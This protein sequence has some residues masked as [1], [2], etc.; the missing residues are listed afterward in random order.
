MA[1]RKRKSCSVGTVALLKEITEYAAAVL[2]ANSDCG[3][4]A[5]VVS[6]V[7]REFGVN[8]W[9]VG[10]EAVRRGGGVEDHRWVVVAS[11]KRTVLSGRGCLFDPAE[12]ALYRTQ[13]RTWKQYLPL[14][15]QQERAPEWD[16]A[17]IIRA[18]EE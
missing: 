4:Y 15:A 7:A 12:W 11:T 17:E 13:G 18:M 8:A 5:S 6:F 10:D 14:W 16:V 3:V 2:P 9:H 1:T